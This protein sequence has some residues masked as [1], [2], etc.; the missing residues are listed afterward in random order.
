MRHCFALQYS[1]KSSLYP[2]HNNIDRD[3]TVKDNLKIHAK[4]FGIKRA[5]IDASIDKAL[6]RVG[7]KDQKY[8]NSGALSGGM[9]RRLVIARALMHEPS[10]LFLD[11]PS[12]GLDPES[13][14]NLYAVIRSLNRDTGVSILLTT[15]YMEEA[16][17]LSSRVIF[18]D[19]GVIAASGKP[20]ELKAA[21]GSYALEYAENNEYKTFYFKSRKDAVNAA[22]LRSGDVKIREITLEDV[23]LKLTGKKMGEKYV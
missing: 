5:R 8:K 15:H 14:R 1:F 22:S 10:V 18:I 23:Y 19:R 3:L 6:D 21:M 12:A 7:L 16:D 2:Q 11:E 20:E 4:L 9:K 13:R 17:I